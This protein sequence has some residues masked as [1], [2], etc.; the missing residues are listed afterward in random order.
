MRDNRAASIKGWETRK[1]MLSSQGFGPKGRK[2]G[3]EVHKVKSVSQILARL[4]SGTALASPETYINT[5]HESGIPSPP[6]PVDSRTNEAGDDMERKA[7]VVAREP[8]TT[9]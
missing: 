6:H 9:G 3:T 4:R 7:S 1:R 8:E 5:D 2:R